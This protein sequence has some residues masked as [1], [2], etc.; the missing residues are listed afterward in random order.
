MSKPD[1]AVFILQIGKQCGHATSTADCVLSYS[2]V[3]ERSYCALGRL[4]TRVPAIAKSG[5]CS[6]L[7]E[8]RGLSRLRKYRSGNCTFVTF[9]AEGNQRSRPCAWHVL[10]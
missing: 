2:I 4:R 5:P 3:R 9:Q 1:H 7:A 10:Y 8:A 6:R